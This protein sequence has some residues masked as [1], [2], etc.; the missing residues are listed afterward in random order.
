MDSGGSKFKSK[1]PNRTYAAR[2]AVFQ[3]PLEYQGPILPTPFLVY[4]SCILAVSA[5]IFGKQ[6]RRRK[7]DPIKT[8]LH[9]PVEICLFIRFF[10]PAF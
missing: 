1:F 8:L 3:I 6:E 9:V 5:V 7:V 4:L 2:I 10:Y